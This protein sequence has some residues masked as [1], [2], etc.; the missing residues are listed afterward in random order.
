MIDPY[1]YATFLDQEYLR[2]Y[3]KDG[4]TAVK[5]V[6]AADDSAAAFASAVGERATAAG[7]L[8]T[9]VDAAE[10]RVHLMDQVFFEVARQ[11][12][13]DD[14]ATR[15]VRGALAAAAYPVPDEQSDVSVDAVAAYHAVD[16]NELARDVN[17]QL[18]QRVHRD[19]AMVAEFRTAMLR[20]C[21]AH[22]GT[23]QVTEAEHAAVLEWLRGDLRQMSQ[24]R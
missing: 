23:G 5:F 11:V 14:L 10:H 17:R 22:L 1:E 6:V 13:W 12:D 19:F 3:V 21:Q 20:L 24:L 18:Q 4:G 16:A 8:T 15:A 2:S 9:V 7:Y